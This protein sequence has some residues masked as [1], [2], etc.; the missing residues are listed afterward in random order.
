MGFDNKKFVV[1]HAAISSSNGSVKFPDGESG[2]E[3][4][5]I[6]S[7]VKG[8]SNCVDVPMYSLDSYAEQFVSSK[9]IVSLLNCLLFCRIDII[10]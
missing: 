5:G 3:A 8:Q 10:Q 1:S 4:F 2:S 6:D 9:G 7:C